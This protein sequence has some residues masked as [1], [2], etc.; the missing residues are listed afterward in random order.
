V[1]S[2]ILKVR[3]KCAALSIPPEKKMNCAPVR[4]LP[5]RLRKNDGAT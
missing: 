2:T 3:G 1:G 5:S 4:E